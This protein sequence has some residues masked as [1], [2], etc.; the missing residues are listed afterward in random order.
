MAKPYRWSASAAAIS[1]SIEGLASTSGPVVVEA[2][3][4]TIR[5]GRPIDDSH[6]PPTGAAVHRPRRLL[7]GMRAADNNQHQADAR[8]SLRGQNRTLG[9]RRE[10][11][12]ADARRVPSQTSRIHSE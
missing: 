11:D 3:I 7:G 12:R 10:L 6:P 1:R 4:V 8:R 9:L 5:Q 2:G